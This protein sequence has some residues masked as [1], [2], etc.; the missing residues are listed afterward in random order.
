MKI[1]SEDDQQRHDSRRRGVRSA[2]TSSEESNDDEE[3]DL[4]VLDVLV[5]DVQ[6]EEDRT[7]KVLQP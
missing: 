1:F 2:A 4:Q 5:P 6:E 3:Q 7:L